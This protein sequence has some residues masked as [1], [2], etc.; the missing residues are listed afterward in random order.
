MLHNT[1]DIYFLYNLELKWLN[2]I[3][4]QLDVTA[5][6]PVVQNVSIVAAVSIL[7]AITVAEAISVDI[8]IIVLLSFICNCNCSYK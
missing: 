3:A 4:N 6:E 5:S 2:I 1:K 7:L 8:N